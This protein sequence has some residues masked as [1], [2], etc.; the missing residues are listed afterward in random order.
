MSVIPILSIYGS[1]T[2]TNIV[3]LIAVK[4]HAPA[5]CQGNDYITRVP[6]LNV[7]EVTEWTLV[8]M[9]VVLRFFLLTASQGGRRAAE[10]R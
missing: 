4:S 10:T 6:A 2:S 1:I 8:L 5:G 9:Y 3:T 7:T